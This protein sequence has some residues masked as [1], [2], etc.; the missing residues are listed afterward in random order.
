MTPVSALTIHPFEGRKRGAVDDL[1]F[2]SNHTQVHLDW[3]TSEQWLATDDAI[4][5]LAWQGDRLA[6]LLAASQPLNGASWVRL[7]S[8]DDSF[9][10]G[11]ILPP[12]W[13]A[14]A[15][16]LRDKGA[17]MCGFLII[18][19]WIETYLPHMNFHEYDEIITLRRT[20]YGLPEVRTAPGLR[21][22]PTDSGDIARIAEVDQTAFTPPWQMS[23]EDLRQ[24]RRIAASCSVV[25]FDDDI[26]GYQLSTRYHHT[27]HLARLAVSP[28]MQGKGVGG[29][30]LVDMIRSFLRRHI[31]TV[32]VNT[33]ASNRRSQQLYERFG[34]ERT[35]FNLPV[36]WASL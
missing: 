32:T 20:G 24:G 15:A 22:R 4:T 26:V 9:S 21:V 30:L 19:T 36:W 13:A 6:G 23:H 25:T 16:I 8:I 33:Q 14:L 29:V 11:D 35:G 18:E 7:V 17:T 5:M 1:L 27:G 10:P 2:Y 28:S 3:H 12:L 31:R 34:F